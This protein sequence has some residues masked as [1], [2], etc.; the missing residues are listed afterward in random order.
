ML[1]ARRNRMHPAPNRISNFLQTQN[2]YTQI[3]FLKYKSRLQYIIEVKHLV[4]ALNSNYM[5]AIGQQKKC[6]I[7]SAVLTIHKN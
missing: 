7:T 3:N 5:L 6:Y 1:T 2:L 4:Y